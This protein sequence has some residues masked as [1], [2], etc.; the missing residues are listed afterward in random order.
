MVLSTNRTIRSSQI[1]K[2]KKKKKTLRVAKEKQKEKNISQIL[3][4]LEISRTYEPK[5]TMYLKEFIAVI[6]IAIIGVVVK[7]EY[8]QYWIEC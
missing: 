8:I 5:Y 6:I 7:N 4:V 3:K 2:K 1:E